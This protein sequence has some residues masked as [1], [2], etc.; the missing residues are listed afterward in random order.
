M[1]EEETHEQLFARLIGTPPPKKKKK[2]ELLKYGWVVITSIVNHSFA[3]RHG[4]I[5]NYFVLDRQG[6]RKAY[7][8]FT[9]CFGE[10]AY[11]AFF[12]MVVKFYKENKVAFLQK[13][14][15][16]ISNF[17]RWEIKKDKRCKNER[18]VI[19]KI[20]ALNLEES[21]WITSTM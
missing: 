6:Q 16:K 14:E 5:F 20:F 18:F 10:N 9:E 8:F 4:L 3:N 7:K 17:L 19:K 12:E 2:K 15:F 1:R 13:R 21:L 11:N